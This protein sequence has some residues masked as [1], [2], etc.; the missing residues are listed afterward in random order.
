MGIMA[1]CDE[2]CWFPKATDKT[3]VEKLTNSHSAHPKFVKSDFKSDADFAILHYAGQVNYSATKWLMKNMDP[4]NENIVQYLQASQDPFVCHIWK[5]GKCN[6]PH[7]GATI[8]SV[9][10]DATA[11]F[12]LLK[13][14][15]LQNNC[16]EFKCKPLYFKDPPYGGNLIKPPW[17]E[18]GKRA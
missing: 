15:S 1:L 11:H 9:S 14:L 6:I 8:T 16:P 18:G 10:K 17:F 4:L 3:F 12:S 5:D 2:E 13:C 7:E